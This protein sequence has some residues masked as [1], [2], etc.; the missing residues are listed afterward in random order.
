MLKQGHV[1]GSLFT[2]NYGNQAWIGNVVVAAQERRR[3]LATEALRTVI[4][5]LRG[6][7]CVKEFRLGAVPLAIDLYQD[8]GFLPES[9]T[10]AQEAQLPIHL[11]ADHFE[12]LG[13]ADVGFRQCPPFAKGEMKRPVDF[14]K[15]VGN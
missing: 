7:T 12:G 9:F 1:I 14:R 3:G 15:V 13:Q 5:Y 10:T 6:S 4:G 2:T 8:I 11:A